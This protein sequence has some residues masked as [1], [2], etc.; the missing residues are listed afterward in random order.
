MIAYFP[1]LED[2]ELVYSAFGRFY[3][4]SGCLVYR[5]AAKQ[6]FQNPY[7]HPSVEFINNLTA[8]AKE[9]LTKQK[10]MEEIIK[11]HTMLPMHIR[12]MSK[13]RRQS[14]YNS[15]LYEDS[16]KNIFPKVVTNDEKR[17]LRYCP[18]CSKED[19]ATYGFTYWHRKHQI[20]GVDVCTKHKVYLNKSN[21]EISGQT[22][23]AFHNA[24]QI[25]PYE[26]E[27]VVCE[28]SL[29]MKLA[30]YITVIFEAPIDFE[31]DYNI[32]KYLTSYIPVDKYYKMSGVER[33]IQ[34]LQTDY[35]QFYESMPEDYLLDIS[36]IQQLLNGKRTALQDVCRFAFFLN[37][38]A[39][40]LI[41]ANN[42]AVTDSRLLIYEAVA[43]STGISIDTIAIIDKA[44]A[45]Q[46]KAMQFKAKKST[47][48]EKWN[49]QDIE[50]LPKIKELCSEL[51]NG[52]STGRP[53]R[54]A[55]KTVQRLLDLP[56][57]R[58]DKLP[59]CRAEI[60]NWQETQ[61]HYWAREIIWAVDKIENEGDVLNW[62]HI[63]TL[64]NIRKSNAEVA[65]P[66][67]EKLDKSLFKIVKELL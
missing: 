41:N 45:E 65:L 19:R 59:Q 62:K 60:E 17:Y 27:V 63:R 10:S 44:I 8:D 58:F 49:K 42:K 55:V 54:V 20:V 22:T 40:E 66:E 47:N 24:E 23:P 9:H 30:E 15:L 57:K 4:N 53:Q 32:G 52:N 37:I 21:I 11:K 67:L 38:D 1:K 50:L 16:N 64:I 3:A 28:N 34:A 36:F 25:L 5:E 26:D 56:D 13:L 29:E 48:Y 7:A 6:L 46:E 39:S 51:Y 31:A 61:A 35:N 2:D 33:D 18:I 12:F 43:S 14:I